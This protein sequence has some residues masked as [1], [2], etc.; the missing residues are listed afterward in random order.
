MSDIIQ[1]T[2]KSFTSFFVLLFDTDQKHSVT[3]R[4][5]CVHICVCEGV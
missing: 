4:A 5:V 2:S 3:A 1:L